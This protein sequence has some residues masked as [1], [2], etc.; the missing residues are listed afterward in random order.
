MS[1]V[2]NANTNREQNE[3]DSTVAIISPYHNDVESFDNPDEF[4]DL[5]FV[6]VGM[7]KPLQLHRRILA[8]ASGKVKGM[9]NERRNL[10]LEWPFDTTKEVDREAL[11]KALRFC[12]GETQIVG[13]KNGECVAMIVALKRLHVTCLD[14]VV[15]LLSNFAMDEAK[16]NVEIGVG[17]LKACVGYKEMS[18]TSQLTLDKKLAAIVLTK[19]N[20]QEHYK[21]VVDEC[22]MVLPPEYLMIAEF[23]EPHTR[24]SEFCLTLRYIRFHIHRLNREQ[25]QAMIAKCDW[26]TLN[27]QELRELRMVDIIDKDELLEAHEKALKQREIENEQATEM[28][29]KIERKM[30]EKVN[31]IEKERD[32]EMKRVKKAEA[33]KEE[34]RLRGA[35]EKQVLCKRIEALENSLKGNRLLRQDTKTSKKTHSNVLKRDNRQHTDADV[36]VLIKHKG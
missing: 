34:L 8:H 29:R 28:T 9:L 18:G 19:G 7:E 30:E 23:G 6:V 13:I 20:M 16:R 12:Y 11:V 15:T 26:S 31:E 21:E 24:W 22:L 35:I 33:D 1:S 27:S 5:E 36:S 2:I 32:E 4:P 10:K 17:L 25:R 3:C 14:D